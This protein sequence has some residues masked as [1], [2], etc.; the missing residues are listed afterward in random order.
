MPRVYYCL[1]PLLFGFIYQLHKYL[2]DILKGGIGK[3]GSTVAVSVVPC[4]T[5]TLIFGVTI[6][7]LSDPI[8]LCCFMLFSY[9]LFQLTFFISLFTYHLSTDH[10]D[11]PPVMTY[12]RAI[13]VGEL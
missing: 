3:N 4:S 11:V 8:W 10:N 2:A 6:S 7:L 5:D 1:V 13:V 12:L 9:F